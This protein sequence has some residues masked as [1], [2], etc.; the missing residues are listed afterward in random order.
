MVVSYTVYILTTTLTEQTDKS[1][2]MYIKLIDQNYVIHYFQNCLCFLGNLSA[3]I[4]D[5]VY[6]E[7]GHYLWCHAIDSNGIS[8]VAKYNLFIE[9]W[10][11][12]SY[13]KFYL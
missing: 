10:K 3:S 2:N 1:Q 11:I 12:C 5:Y 9:Y 8:L 13:L 7:P 4:Y 6:L